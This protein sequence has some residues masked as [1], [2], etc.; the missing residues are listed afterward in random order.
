[1]GMPRFAWRRRRPEVSAART[2]GKKRGV[3]GSGNT[4]GEMVRIAT[5]GGA[6]SATE[7]SAPT[8][9]SPSA[10]ALTRGMLPRMTHVD[11]GGGGADTVSAG[12]WCAGAA[13]SRET[14]GGAARTVE[15]AGASG[16]GWDTS[17]AAVD[18]VAGG[19]DDIRAPAGG[20]KRVSGW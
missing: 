3:G 19:G 8:G 2:N 15:P 11:D 16:A 4:S 20:D 13:G 12:C 9:S 14:H 6:A 1:M 7:R 10:A 18:S 5:R 17:A